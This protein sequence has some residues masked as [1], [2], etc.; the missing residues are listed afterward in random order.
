MSENGG[1]KDNHLTNLEEYERQKYSK[2]TKLMR[3]GHTLRNRVIRGIMIFVTLSILKFYFNSNCHIC[4][5]EYD[6]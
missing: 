3:N 2:A 4:K 1:K 5:L 6:F